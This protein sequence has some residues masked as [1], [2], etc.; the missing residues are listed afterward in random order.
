[1][2]LQYFTGLNQPCNQGFGGSAAAWTRPLPSP[3]NGAIMTVE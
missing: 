2:L 1:M 3:D